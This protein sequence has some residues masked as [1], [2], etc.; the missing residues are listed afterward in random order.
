MDK[1]N[2][3]EWVASIETLIDNKLRKWKKESRIENGEAV[4]VEWQF[5][6][7][8]IIIDFFWHD[9]VES[10]FFLYHSP[11]VNHTYLWSGLNDETFNN[12]V[13]RVGNLAQM[14]MY[15]LKDYTD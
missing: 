14:A 15:P 13:D 5:G 3:R 6:Q 10:V 9:G 7:I 2:M 11:R 1:I 8:H 4:Q 12:I